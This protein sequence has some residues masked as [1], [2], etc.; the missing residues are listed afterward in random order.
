MKIVVTDV[1]E[2]Y[3]SNV[4]HVDGSAQECSISTATALLH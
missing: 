4:M 3:F 1:H 2:C